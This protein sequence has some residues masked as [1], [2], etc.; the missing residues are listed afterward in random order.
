MNAVEMM[1]LGFCQRLQNGE[2]GT[3]IRESLWVFPLVE[4]CHILGLFL[5]VGVVIWFDL[6]LAGIALK[7]ASVTEVSTQI[8]PVSIVGFALMFVSG[9]LLL[10]ANPAKLYGN[11]YFRIK[12]LLLLLAGCNAVIFQLTV[13]RKLSEWDRSPVPPVQARVAGYLSLILWFGIIFAG[14]YTAFSI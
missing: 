5:S 13:H 12:V 3:A 14:R 8:L 7:K 9:A 4:S 1:V 2:I 11:T 10:W 6:R